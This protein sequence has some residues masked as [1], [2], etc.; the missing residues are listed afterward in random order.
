MQL[1]VMLTRVAPKFRCERRGEKDLGREHQFFSFRHHNALMPVF[2]L[3]ASE[4]LTNLT[5]DAS[6][7]QY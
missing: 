4:F 7:H 1:G 2:A 6:R 3:L 5:I